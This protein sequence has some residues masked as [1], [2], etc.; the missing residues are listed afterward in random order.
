MGCWHVT[1]LYW[2]SGWHDVAIWNLQACVRCRESLR[3]ACH[4]EDDPADDE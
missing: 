2:D 4:M 3:L 1:P